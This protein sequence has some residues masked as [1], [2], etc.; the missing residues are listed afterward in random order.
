MYNIRIVGCTRCDC[1]FAI[2]FNRYVQYIRVL[3][4][5]GNM[6]IVLHSFARKNK[7]FPTQSNVLQLARV[8]CGRGAGVLEVL[9]H[10]SLWSEIVFKNTLMISHLPSLGPNYNINHRS[11]RSP[12]RPCDFWFLFFKVL[13]RLAENS[14]EENLLRRIK[15]LSCTDH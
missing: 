8:V 15:K 14:G 11:I 1:S 10:F 9:A 13:V 4:H 2:Y 7:T 5:A 6:Q 3:C 12:N